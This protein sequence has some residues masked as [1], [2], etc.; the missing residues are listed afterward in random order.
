MLFVHLLVFSWSITFI[1]WQSLVNG[2]LIL[3]HLYTAHA[4]SEGSDDEGSE[5]EISVIQRTPECSRP[6]MTTRSV[7]GRNLLSSFTIPN[8]S[9]GYKNFAMS[10][11]HNFAHCL[12][13][14]VDMDSLNPT[15]PHQSFLVLGTFY[16]K[17]RP[18]NRQKT[19]LVRTQSRLNFL[20]RLCMCI[21]YFWGTCR[22]YRD[23]FHC[24]MAL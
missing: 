23:G 10:L 3:T 18:V 16:Q 15:K 9:N 14:R 19:D 12:L 17:P 5:K 22:F 4:S 11:S 7:P 24:C 2:C 8:L 6:K 21:M 20:L 1:F 13:Y